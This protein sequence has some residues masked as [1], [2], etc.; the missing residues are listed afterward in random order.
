MRSLPGTAVH[1][2]KSLLFGGY[3]FLLVGHAIQIWRGAILL[4][5]EAMLF[6]EVAM[7]SASAASLM[8]IESSQN[9]PAGRSW[10]K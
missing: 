7:R 8:S 6:A 4:A 5:E 3:A 2:R 1:R 9:L 10:A